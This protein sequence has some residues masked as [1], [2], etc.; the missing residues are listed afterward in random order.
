MKIFLSLLN[1]DE[2]VVLD[3]YYYDTSFQKQIKEKGCK[4]ICI[5]DIH[6]RHFYCDVIFCPDPCHPA[7]YSAEPF[8]EIYC[9][10]EWAF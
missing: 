9:G 8:T 4:L 7:D 10:M 2:I 1:G 6:T 3:N 5:D